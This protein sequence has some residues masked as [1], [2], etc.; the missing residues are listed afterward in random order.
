MFSHGNNFISSSFISRLVLDE[1]A[2][3]KFRLERVNSYSAGI[4]FSR[5]IMTTKVDPRTVRVV[6]LLMAVYP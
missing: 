3:G 1:D 6:I 4:D 5:Q 2:N